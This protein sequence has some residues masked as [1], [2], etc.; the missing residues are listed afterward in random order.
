MYCRGMTEQRR[1]S[2][3]AA[4]RIALAAQGFARPRP[5]GRITRQHLRRV[6]D[7]IGLI[8]VDS[9]N[10]L[11][12]SQE[13]PLFSRLGPHPR[14]LIPDAI[15]A[16]ELFEYWVHAASILPTAHRHL[17]RWR[18]E[19]FRDNTENRWFST[20]REQVER[21]LQQITDQGGLVVG[22]VHGRVR[23]KGGT[24]WDW[25]DAKIALEKLFDH[26]V[27]AV[28][29]RREDFARRYD[30]VERLIPAHVLATPAAPEREARR[31]L[32]VLAARSLGV[33]T[34]AD[35]CDYHR[36]SIPVCKPLVAE[37]V[38]EG[39]LVPVTVD[40]WDKPAFVH[41]DAAAPRRI[42]GRALLSPFDS[43]IWRR[44]RTERIFDFSYRLEIY[45]PKPKRVFG[46][47]VLPFMLD[48]QLAGRVDLKADRAA[49]ALRVQAAHVEPDLDTVSD[50]PAI[51][52]A[53]FA[54]LTDMARW[55]ELD[56]V[57]AVERGNLA[58]DLVVAGAE[59]VP[60]DAAPSMPRRRD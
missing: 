19:R 16:G 57:V 28:T 40:G 47:Y 8:Q 34:I 59:I 29:R 10:V 9:V 37:L 17:W 49:G 20:H 52:E 32:L 41:P 23:N 48:G 46:Y 27:V 45:T 53:L 44:E 60:A 14:T 35:L 43:L 54:E 51:A 18:M 38:T 42:T 50:R 58:K 39:A 5:S 4:R 6:F 55:L 24:W 11:V 25:D 30:L 7:D 26:G 15:D 21:V 22:E 2:A 3:D 33:G 36:M 1:V 12:R 56:D 31:E 13:L